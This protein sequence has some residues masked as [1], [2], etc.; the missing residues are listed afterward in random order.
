MQ[1]PALYC[2]L[3]R[4][5]LCRIVISYRHR[6]RHSYPVPRRL[7]RVHA[8]GDWTVEP[9]ELGEELPD[10]YLGHQ[11]VAGEGGLV[12]DRQYGVCDRVRHERSPSDCHRQLRDHLHQR[13]PDCC[14]NRL[15]PDD[16]QGD[17]RQ[18][19][20]DPVELVHG[21]GRHA[22]GGGLEQPLR[23][24]PNHVQPVRDHADDPDAKHVHGQ[25]RDDGDCDGLRRPDCHDHVYD[26]G[27]RVHPELLRLLYWNWSHRL[28][29]VN[30]WIHTV[31]RNMLGFIG[32]IWI[33]G[34]I[35]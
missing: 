22:D 29:P 33:I 10:L 32:I 35:K 2:L 1:A 21:L 30:V 19:R 12:P 17:G 25:L 16:V 8:N 31:R 15:S 3:Q 23:S 9:A 4:C 11:P 20:L 28:H 6:S 24:D 5:D 7:S 14:W 13:C 27:E 26:D 34:I 18:D